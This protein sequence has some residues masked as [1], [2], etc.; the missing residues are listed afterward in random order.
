[1]EEI[2]ISELSEAVRV[3]DPRPF[4]RQLDRYVRLADLAD[5]HMRKSMPLT[6]KKSRKYEDCY[7]D[8]VRESSAILS[9]ST[10]SVSRIINFRFKL[11]GQAS[12]VPEIDRQTVYYFQKLRK[13]QVELLS[14]VGDEVEIIRMLIRRSKKMQSMIQ[15]HSLILRKAGLLMDV[16]RERVEKRPTTLLRVEGRDSKI[17]ELNRTFGDI[18]LYENEYEQ[19]M[20]PNTKNHRQ[21]AIES[22]LMS[23][24]DLLQTSYDDIRI[25]KQRIHSS[26]KEMKQGGKLM[27]KLVTK[28]YSPLMKR[29]LDKLVSDHENRIREFQ[30]HVRECRMAYYS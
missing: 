4:M 7:T 10:L 2:S 23:C 29:R 18:Q 21:K 12:G 8:I 16:V 9:L 14:T 15:E 22:A 25:R 27:L 13:Q 28:G 17:Q 11:N 26:L 1:M 6:E 20:G 24:N 30:N 5:R 19:R 3:P